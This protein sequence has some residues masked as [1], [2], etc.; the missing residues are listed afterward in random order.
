MI[1]DDDNFY[2]ISNS[3][4]NIGENN[5]LISL[6]DSCFLNIN[7]LEDKIPSD[8]YFGHQNVYEFG[9]IYFLIDQTSISNKSKYYYKS[10]F[11]KYFNFY[12][13]IC[14]TNF[15][16]DCLI[17]IRKNEIFFPNNFYYFFK[18]ILQYKNEHLKRICYFILK[19]LRKYANNLELDFTGVKF[20]KRKSQ[21]KKE[22]PPKNIEKYIKFLYDK[23]D[24]KNLLVFELIYKFNAHIGGIAE[25]TPEDIKKGNIAI[26]IK[27]LGKYYFKEHRCYKKLK[28]YIK[29]IRIK[30]MIIFL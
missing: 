26:H 23:K 18:Y 28:R 7:S 11:N 13:K 10:L 25:M 17:E 27:N 19:I 6:N 22:I 8:T 12:E 29:S 1:N 24:I 14:K 20:D 9:K 3:L 4:L 2:D 30:K 5:S 15:Q 16:N 21:E